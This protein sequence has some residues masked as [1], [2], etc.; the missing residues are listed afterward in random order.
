MTILDCHER[1]ARLTTRER[2]ALT[3]DMAF[4]VRSPK[5]ECD[6]WPAAVVGAL[7]LINW[8]PQLASDSD[9][10]EAVAHVGYLLGNDLLDREELE[11]EAMRVV[12]EIMRW[13]D[14]AEEAVAGWN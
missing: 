12:D 1:L 7:V 9:L 8:L 14:A 13:G 11:R 6:A 4:R 10:R 5:G 2:R 3:P